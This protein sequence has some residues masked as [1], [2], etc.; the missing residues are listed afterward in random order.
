[1]L[2]ALK[3]VEL[4]TFLA[5]V[6]LAVGGAMIGKLAD[7]PIRW[8]VIA[9]GV[10]VFLGGILL[11]LMEPSRFGSIQ[12]WAHKSQAG[13][14]EILIQFLSPG[15]LPRPDLL[16]LESSADRNLDADLRTLAAKKRDE[17]LAARQQAGPAG[18]QTMP[19]LSFWTWEQTL[20]GIAH[21]FADGRGPLRRVILIGSRETV[22]QVQSFFDDVVCRY[23]Q[24]R[25][26]VTFQVLLKNLENRGEL[27]TLQCGQA[28]SSRDNGFD[29][30]DFDEIAEALERLLELLQLDAPARTSVERTVQIDFTGGQKPNSVVAAVATVLSRITNQY[31][32]TNPDNP[33]AEPWT[34]TV[35]GYDAHNRV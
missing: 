5:I 35:W 6:L 10:P 3:R 1:M 21:N 22:A 24:L 4:R 15:S 33:D 25:D 20:R 18:L 26:R 28:H 27:K 9:C 13:Q 19:R 23:P 11:Q 7:S 8:G 17:Y 16:D 34:Y 31:V 30:E 32:A 29:F 12:T 2:P 14:R